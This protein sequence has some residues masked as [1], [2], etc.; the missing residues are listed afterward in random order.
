MKPKCSNI[1]EGPYTEHVKREIF[2]K[3]RY[4]FFFFSLLTLTKESIS[5][6]EKIDRC[7]NNIVESTYTVVLK[8]LGK[9]II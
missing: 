7:L 5:F 1:F 3:N 6:L 2:K 9:G 4:D 8:D